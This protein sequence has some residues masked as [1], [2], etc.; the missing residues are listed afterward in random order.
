V[1]VWHDI[2]CIIAAW[3]AFAQDIEPEVARIPDTLLAHWKMA[4]RVVAHAADTLLVVAGIL[5][6]RADRVV[7]NMSADFAGHSTAAAGSLALPT[8]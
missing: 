5:A 8:W 3:E 4:G 2:W 6:H 1:E 7:D